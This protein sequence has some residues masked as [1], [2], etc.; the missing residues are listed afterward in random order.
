MHAAGETRNLAKEM[1]E[2]VAQMRVTLDTFV[3]YVPTLTKG[4][5]DCYN[6]SFNVTEMWSGYPGP[7]CIAKGAA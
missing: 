4:N 5:L 3:P 2:T 6:C 1:P 7:G